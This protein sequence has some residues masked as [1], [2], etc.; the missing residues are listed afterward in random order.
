MW[1]G[2]SF[3]VTDKG[4]WNPRVSRL[5]HVCEGSSLGGIF[6]RGVSFHQ[7]EVGTRLPVLASQPWPSSGWGWWVMEVSGVGVE[8]PWQ[9]G[10]ENPGGGEAHRLWEGMSPGSEPG[11]QICCS[12]SRKAHRES[13][14]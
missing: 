8:G 4:D 13:W 10:K 11:L 5:H 7:R 9:E 2:G 6:P 1:A 14:A 12:P 3:P